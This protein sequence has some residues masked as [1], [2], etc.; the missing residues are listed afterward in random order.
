[1]F[2]TPCGLFIIVEKYTL[3]SIPFEFC[4]SLIVSCHD[5]GSVVFL[6]IHGMQKELMNVK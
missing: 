5:L 6:N 4:I 3:E 1:M 2:E